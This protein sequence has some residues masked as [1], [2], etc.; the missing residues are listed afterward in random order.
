MQYKNVGFNASWA[1]A[2]SFEEFAK[3][4]AHHG[5]S[6]KELEDVYRKCCEMEK[7]APRIEAKPVE[8]PKAEK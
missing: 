5:F 8:A 7:V 1:A 6:E 3:Q 2:H 4:E